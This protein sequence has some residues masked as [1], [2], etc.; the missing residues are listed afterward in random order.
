MSNKKKRGTPIT[1]SDIAALNAYRDEIE[2]NVINFPQS[3]PTREQ[4]AL[5]QALV[6]GLAVQVAVDCMRIAEKI[7]A[8]NSAGELKA[9]IIEM[10]HKL[11]GHSAGFRA[12]ASKVAVWR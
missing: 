3:A 5:S 2:S 11:D 6:N 1:A 8:A 12:L 7:A 4:M 10:Q 9:A